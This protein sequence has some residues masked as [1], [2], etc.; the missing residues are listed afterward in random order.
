VLSLDFELAWGVRDTLGS[1]GPYRGNLLGAR[2][3]VPRL[4]DRFAAHD[5]AATWATVG[6]L[7]A[8]SRDE[9]LAR[10]PDVR[11][12]YADPR[13]DPYRALEGGEV[14][15]DERR[16]PV[17]FAASL[18]RLIASAPRQELGSHTYAHLYP[19]EP[20]VTAAAVA[21]DLAAARAMGR[22]HGHDLRSLVMP[23]HQVRAVDL[24]SVAAAGFV[25]HRGPEPNALNRPR[26][27]V[28]GPWIVRALRLL[29]GY[30]PLTGA[31]DAPWPTPDAHGLVDVPEGRFLRPASRRLGALE[32]RRVARVVAAMTVAARRGTLCH[33]WWHPH[34]F[35]ADQPANFANL[36][37]LLEAYA[38]LHDAYG[39]RSW[40]MGDI[41]D[42]VRP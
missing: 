4:L 21:A 39:F 29:D 3:A 33:V 37:A 32:P 27:G 8:G 12:A 1:D 7:F 20:G 35:G 16:D 6:L 30:L 13:L 10:A 18:V 14:G 5:V 38:R 26:P 22:A 40:S 9:A 34:N 17:H 41:A 25:A 2:E 42:A 28:G 24:P 19:M 15:D 36:D 11:P 23:R 31:N